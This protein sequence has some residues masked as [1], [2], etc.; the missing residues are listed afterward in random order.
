[1]LLPMAD[2]WT[3][4]GA[5]GEVVSSVGAV[6]AV[7]IAVITQRRQE[8]TQRRSQ[9]SR[10]TLDLRIGASRDYKG[11]D[12]DYVMVLRV[13]NR[14]D[15]PIYEMKVYSAFNPIIR[16]DELNYEP[17][18]IKRNGRGTE[19]MDPNSYF[20]AL[21]TGTYGDSA[22][23]AEDS[24]ATI[25]WFT[26]A[27]GRHW[28]RKLNGALISHQSREYKDRGRRRRKRTAPNPR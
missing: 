11:V 22:T 20:V 13:D 7:L 28:E 15:L 2:P 8:E 23:Y 21:Y 18:W 4:A 26:D 19:R 16:P 27:A 6:S 14:S 10:V 12:A 1:M 25:L 5:V 3:I 9:A 17:D 24:A